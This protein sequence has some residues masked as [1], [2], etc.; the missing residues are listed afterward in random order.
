MLNALAE[1]AWAMDIP[2]DQVL[3]ILKAFTNAINGLPALP[4]AAKV[5]A[6]RRLNDEAVRAFQGRPSRLDDPALLEDFLDEFGWP[7]MPPATL[8][9]EHLACSIDGHMEAY[10]AALRRGEAPVPEL[11]AL[12]AR[13]AAPVQTPEPEWQ[14]KEASKPP[15]SVRQEPPAEARAPTTLRPG[16]PDGWLAHCLA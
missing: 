5:E 1:V 6:E 2:D 15:R 4:Q 16:D 10:E 14:A 3:T 13:L 12:R 7:E 11:E 8:V 9:A